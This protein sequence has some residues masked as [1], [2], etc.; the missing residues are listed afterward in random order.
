MTMTSSIGTL[1]SVGAQTQ[2]SFREILPRVYEL[3][4]MLVDPSHP[5]AYCQDFEDGLEKHTSK[6]NAFVKL[7][8]Q[9]AVLDDEA[10][11]DL[12][13]RAALHLVSQ[14]REQGRG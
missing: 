1:G 12:K 6:L 9:L 5:N 14:T 11:S 8:R 7:E 3:K 4:D 13:E 10:W 2:S